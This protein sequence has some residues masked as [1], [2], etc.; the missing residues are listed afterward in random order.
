MGFLDGYHDL[1]NTGTGRTRRNPTYDEIANN[2]K[3][4]RDEEEIL[5][6]CFDEAE[7]LVFNRRKNQSV[8]TANTPSQKT[9]GDEGNTFEDVVFIPKFSGVRMELK[10]GGFDCF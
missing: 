6:V 3:D 9:H 7:G 10:Y 2:K 1:R 5:R 4:R 8:E